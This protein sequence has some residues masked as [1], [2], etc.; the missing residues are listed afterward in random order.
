MAAKAESIDSGHGDFA[1]SEAAK[2]I[3]YYSDYFDTK[4]PLQKSSN[5]SE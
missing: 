5:E 1:L 3:D 4:Y 2:I